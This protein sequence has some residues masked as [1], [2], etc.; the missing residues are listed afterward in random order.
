MILERLA[1]IGMLNDQQRATSISH[2]LA[3]TV[4]PGFKSTIPFNVG[5]E[6][7]MSANSAVP[8]L[9][10]IE[11][12][13]RDA[14]M[15]PAAGAMQVSN[16]G[17][18][19]A[20]EGDAWFELNGQNGSLFTRAGHLRVDSG[21]NL[22]GPRDLPI[23]GDNGPVQLAGDK[24]SID[25]DGNVIQNGAAVARLRRVRFENPAALIAQ[26]DGTYAQGSAR[27]ADGR[28]TDPIRR[29]VLEASNVDSAAEMIKLT[30]TVRH[31]ESLQK[32]VQGYDSTLESTIRK[33]GEF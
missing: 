32:I 15:N 26:G 21:G 12:G 19:I 31:F 10:F 28:A 14:A 2:N 4:T 11:T 33:L 17:S 16:A 6:L 3:N 9:D 27:I 7:R 8:Q 5:F 20:I 25:G 22:L 13:R 30:E 23:L 24:F 1:A 29:G 18:D